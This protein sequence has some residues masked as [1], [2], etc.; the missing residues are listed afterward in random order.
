MEPSTPARGS[1]TDW[2]LAMQD[3]V[4]R[5][6]YGG[7]RA[8]FSDE[9]VAFGTA[10]GAAVGL[11]ELESLQWRRVWPRTRQFTYDL[12]RTRVLDAQGAI[13]VAASWRSLGVAP[14]GTEFTRHGRATLL[15]EPRD[16]RLV[17]TH[18]HFSL[19]PDPE[20]GAT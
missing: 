9:V 4:R 11:D 12:D 5:C 20:S 6:D 14:D 1:V 8:L 18:S 10:A 2:L 17:A 15:L 3:H 13:C 7:A 16:D 19:A